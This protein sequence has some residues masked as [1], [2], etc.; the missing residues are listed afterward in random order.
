MVD[1]PEKEAKLLQIIEC[2]HG[3]LMKYVTMV[4]RGTIPPAQTRAG[5]DAKEMLRTISPRGS[6]MN[7][8]ET[9]RACKML[10]LAFHQ[11]TT[12]E[13][14]DTFLLGLIK[15]ARKYDPF[16]TDKVE[17]VC[18]TIELL[19]KQFTE[20][21]V[22]DRVGYD[23]TGILR[24]LVRKH[25]LRSVTGKKKVVGY[26][27][28]EQWPPDQKLFESGP[29]GFVYVLQ[30]WF[31]YYVNEYFMGQIG[32]IEASGNLLQRLEV[33]GEAEIGGEVLLPHPEGNCVS[34]NGDLRYMADRSL[35]DLTM[36]VSK[37]S[38]DWVAETDDK[39][40]KNLTPQQR[41]L[42]YLH[43]HEEESWKQIGR[44][45]SIDAQ[46]AKNRF[47]ATLEAIRYEA[48]M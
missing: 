8:E 27:K 44:A 22:L 25:Y 30:I 5:R 33:F 18:A 16:Y 13:I 32:Q 12:E 3:Y 28:G 42:L 19:P 21:H 20:Q 14:Y 11:A 40:F 29:I 35:L 23:S 46:T 7:R 26:T 43:F 48:D 9:D 24:S 41:M 47:M 10:H 17:E 45:M 31:R 39:L 2:F 36:D 1:S 37:M 34:A 38:L 4:I 15:A 6:V